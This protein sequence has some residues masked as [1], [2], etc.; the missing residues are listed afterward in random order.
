MLSLCSHRYTA[1]Y[2]AFG[3]SG[4]VAWGAGNVAVAG[5]F[6]I[7]GSALF[8][9]GSICYLYNAHTI[10]PWRSYDRDTSVLAN[11]FGIQPTWYGSLVFLAGSLLFLAGT[12]KDD[13]GAA[14]S[15]PLYQAGIVLFVVGRV[16]FLCPAIIAIK[17]G[18]EF[19]YGGT[20]KEV[21]NIA[22]AIAMGIRLYSKL[23]RVR[24]ERR[25]RQ[26]HGSPAHTTH[27]THLPPDLPTGSWTRKAKKDAQ[28]R[29]GYVT[30]EGGKAA[31][32]ATVRKNDGS[33]VEA[34]TVFE[35]MDTYYVED[36]VLVEGCSA[37]AAKLSTR[38]IIFMCNLFDEMDYEGEGFLNPHVLHTFTN[39]MG[40]EVTREQVTKVVRDLD[41][42]GGR[43][44]GGDIGLD[45]A[46]FM[47]LV[48]TSLNGYT[49]AA[50][51]DKAWQKFDAEGTGTVSAG[52]LLKILRD[53]MQMLYID[54]GVVDEFMTKYGG[55]MCKD[56]LIAIFVGEDHRPKAE[57]GGGGRDSFA[58][59]INANEQI[60][61]PA[62]ALALADNRLI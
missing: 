32:H 24:L 57:G 7:A 11:I 56:D 38:D 5:A 45:F 16:L 20:G 33:W 47:M 61:D 27:A 19:V 22:A 44:T 31:L 4:A 30:L 6:G 3:I 9:A 28:G 18:A 40:V 53:D 37:G 35:E 36:G 62:E 15:L 1:G 59:E 55:A 2:L 29:R 34:T 26:K 39:A 51:M 8:T 12:W 25:E 42:D 48:S 14:G 49:C 17:S 43:H 58:L 41:L 52:T 21:Q 50:E 13:V 46:E 60:E 10:A 54:A 23:T